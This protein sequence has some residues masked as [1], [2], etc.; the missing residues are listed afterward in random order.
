MKE[1]LIP[2][3]IVEELNK[4]IISQEDAKK[5]V[6]ISLRNRYRRKQIS[7]MKL[8]NEI[9]PK[10]IILI[11][12]TGVGKTEIARRLAT[13]TDSPFIKVEATKYT[14][15]GY[16]GKDVESMI[17][18][19]VSITFNKLKVK[20][21]ET[22]K[23][24]YQEVTFL[25]V[26]KLIKPYGTINPDEKNILL[27]EVKSGKYDDQEIEV[28]KHQNSD[29]PMVEVFATGNEPDEDGVKGIIDNIMSSFPGGKKKIVKMSVKNAIEYFLRTEIEQNID[30]EELKPLAIEKVEEDGIVFIDEIDK[31]AEREGSNSEVSRQGVQRD[32]LPI[33][34][35]TT[36]M[37]K[38]GSVRTE[39]ILFIAAGAFTQ[40]SPSDLMPEL[41]GRFPIKVRLNTLNKDDFVKI[42]TEIDFNLLTQ[43]RE[44]LKTDKV[45]LSF[46]KGAI[47]EI[48]EIAIDLNEEIE[49]IGA[50]R[51]AGVIEKI[52]NDIMFE[53][54]YEKQTTIKIGKK[55]VVKIFNYDFVEEN[56]DNYI[57]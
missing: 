49:N 15:V 13:I 37:T 38:Y 2:K 26:A 22:L 1:K 29:A 35:G 20:K 33:I 27:D 7:D 28:E 21:I 5:N 57:L 24:K 32:I 30:L 48:A 17:K 52:L 4:Y 42:L 3:K 40:A 10:N 44:L 39:H 8:K 47:E 56:L 9:T 51:L 18:D 50:R 19:L 54:P 12:P 36:V 31:I 16:V 46:T 53:A 14:E 43:Y 34:E 41:Q 25:K 45:N 23:E 11:G 55:D 6:A